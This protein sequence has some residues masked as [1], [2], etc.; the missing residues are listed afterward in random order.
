MKHALFV[1]LLSISIP[2][3]AV[4]IA[5]LNPLETIEI[6]PEGFKSAIKYNIT[7][8][9]KYAEDVNKNYFVLF[10][11]HPRSQPF[12]SGMHDWLS[13][14]GEWPWLKTIVVTPADYNAE[15]AGVF[16]DLVAN[17]SNQRI[18]DIL[19]QG[20]LK[21]V[22]EKYRTN[23]YRIFNGFMSNGALG[24]YTLLN[25]PSMFDAYLIA[26]PTLNNDFARVLSDAPT[27]LGAQYDGMKFLYMAIGNHNYEKAHIESFKQFE[28]YLAKQTN[29][30]LTW[31][32]NNSENHYYMSRPVVTLLNGIEAL[33][34]D[35]HHDLAAD[36]EVSQRGVD[37]IITY[38]DK[39]SKH[40]YGFEISAEG[41][42]K[43]LAKSKVAQNPSEALEI[44]T[45]VTELYPDSAYAHASLAKALADQGDVKK[46]IHVQSIALEKSKSMGQWHQ[47]KHQQFLDEFKNMMK[48]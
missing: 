32:S 7:L 41:S 47:D 23:G 6:K 16:E 38:Y 9:H 46:A 29:P 42:L 14:N 36:S 21:K 48:H 34:D 5:A 37:A 18:L 45:K 8:P 12:I 11:M 31:Q 10:D 35:I 19:Q 33:F 2:C 20:I 40:K 44:Y 43:S 28:N 39:L 13:H 24:L 26:S 27:K 1:I 3:L 15:F 30:Q 25:R 22:D 4:D 17:P